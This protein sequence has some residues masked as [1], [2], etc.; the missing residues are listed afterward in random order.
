LVNLLEKGTHTRDIVA[1]V[2]DFYGSG[3]CSGFRTPIIAF[4]KAKRKN[5]ASKLKRFYHPLPWV[6]YW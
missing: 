4:I 5:I 6:I 2:F 3:R 1:C